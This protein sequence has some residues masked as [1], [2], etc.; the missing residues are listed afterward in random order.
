MSNRESGLAGPEL[1][2][3]VAVACHGAVVQGVH[4]ILGMLPV[5]RRTGFTSWRVIDLTTQSTQGGSAFVQSSSLTSYRVTDSKNNN[6]THATH[7]TSV[8]VQ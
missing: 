7:A 8:S 1:Q 5:C 4:L 3:G 6:T 2:L